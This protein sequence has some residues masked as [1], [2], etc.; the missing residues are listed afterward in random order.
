MCPPARAGPTG[1]PIYK[2]KNFA[3]LADTLP[4]ITGMKIVSK[5]SNK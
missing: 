5:Y 3:P 1:T 2:V 4:K